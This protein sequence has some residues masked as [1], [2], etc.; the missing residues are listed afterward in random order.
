MKRKLRNF[1]HD[2]DGQAVAELALAI[3]VLLLVLLAIV[4]FGRA[5]NY[6][7][8]ENHVGSIG[9]RY[10]AVGGTVGMCGGAGF[11]TTCH[12]L[13]V[14]LSFDVGIHATSLLAGTR[15]WY[16]LT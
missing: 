5:V 1:F 16:G 7:N 10:A 8:D 4:D 9:S 12:L 2:E 6:W 3:P 11:S 15:G 14:Y 13:R